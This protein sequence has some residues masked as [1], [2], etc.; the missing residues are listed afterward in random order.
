[1]SMYL[2]TKGSEWAIIF[3]ERLKI[4][5]DGLVGQVPWREV[6]FPSL[7]QLNANQYI[8]LKSIRKLYSM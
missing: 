6:S 8:V 3:T 5:N 2:F 4:S 1:M 7:L